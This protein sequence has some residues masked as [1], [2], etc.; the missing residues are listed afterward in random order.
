M[1]EVKEWVSRELGDMKRKFESIKCYI[2]EKDSQYRSRMDNRVY[3]MQ[4]SVFIAGLY[5]FYNIQYNSIGIF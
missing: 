1:Q 5:I 4:A 2:S 3:G